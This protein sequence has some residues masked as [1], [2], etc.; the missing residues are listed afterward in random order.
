MER[1]VQALVRLSRSNPAPL[2]GL[3]AHDRHSN[4]PAMGPGS[5][6]R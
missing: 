5:P 4:E 3:Y 1:G 6:L 2:V